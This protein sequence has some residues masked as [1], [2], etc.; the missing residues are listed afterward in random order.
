MLSSHCRGHRHVGAPV[1]APPQRGAEAAV[2]AEVMVRA[3]EISRY[4]RI[5]VRCR[6][7]HSAV[8]GAIVRAVVFPAAFPAMRSGRRASAVA[9]LKPRRRRRRPHFWRTSFQSCPPWGTQ[10]R[11][12][13]SASSSSSCPPRC[14]SCSRALRTAV[15]GTPSWSSRAAIS[16]RLRGRR[17]MRPGQLVGEV[18]G[19]GFADALEQRGVDLLSRAQPQAASEGARAAEL[20]RVVEADGPSG[21]AAFDFDDSDHGDTCLSCTSGAGLHCS[22]FRTDIRIQELS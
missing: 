20:R 15:S 22:A 5:R 10:R 17:S 8:R 4:R 19:G 18:G 12:R 7:A 11:A 3:I 6:W 1:V 9:A 14:S 16:R 13:E 21:S 2:G